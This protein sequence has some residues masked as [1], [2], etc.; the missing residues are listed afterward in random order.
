MTSSNL[1]KRLVGCLLGTAAGDAIGLPFEKLS[2]RRLAK[3]L[4]KPDRHRFLFG[5]GM[6][7]DD[8]ENSCLVAESLIV[9]RGDVDSFTREF[10]RRMRWWMAL[11]P[12]GIGRATLR[13][14]VKLWFGASPM[15]SGV[16]SAANGP[17]M[18]SALFGAAYESVETIIKF[19]RAS[20][21][22]THSDPKAEYAAIAVALAAYLACQATDIDS[23][24][25][26]SVVENAIGPDGNE[27]LE[28]LRR[29]AASVATNQSTLDFAAELGLED[30]VTGYAYHTVPVAI[31]SWL[32]YPNDFRE[33]VMSVIECG[34]DADTTA[35]IVG[36]IVGARGGVEGIPKDWLDGISEWPRSLSWIESL[37]NEC[38]KSIQGDDAASVPKLNYPGVLLRNLFFMAVV[39][40]H[41]FRR[42][43]PPY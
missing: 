33:A 19:T 38:S 8:T 35:A 5:R 13:A 34:G 30:G 20:C 37:A 10:A 26:L 39:L 25:Y 17:A 40:V 15:R 21:L 22:V 9:S 27:L 32:S 3:L 18:R 43:L 36:G 12:A 1:E 28:L 2:R 41:G 29:A 24:E 4:G 16:Y 42:L 11:L 31:H 7:S 14:C 6:I 23:N